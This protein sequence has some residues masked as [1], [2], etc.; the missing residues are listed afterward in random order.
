MDNEHV[1][2]VDGKQ[3]IELVLMFLVRSETYRQLPTLLLLKA[4]IV[5]I[6]RTVFIVGG[7]I[8]TWGFCMF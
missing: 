6:V 8:S 2:A 3:K 7:G 1:F 4:V 5:K